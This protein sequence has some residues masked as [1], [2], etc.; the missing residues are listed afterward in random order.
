MIE[1]CINLSGGF[2]FSWTRMYARQVH[3]KVFLS[4]D[5]NWN[6]FH[7]CKLP[8]ISLAVMVFCAGEQ[9]SLTYQFKLTRWRMLVQFFLTLRLVCVI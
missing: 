7:T 8:L 1:P 3:F 5:S 6:R 9:M 2:Q 4:A